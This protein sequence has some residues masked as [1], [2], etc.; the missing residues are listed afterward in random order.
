MTKMQIPRLKIALQFFESILAFMG[1]WNCVVYSKL[2]M[3]ILAIF[4]IIIS[5]VSLWISYSTSKKT[6]NLDLIGKRPYLV[7]A[8]AKFQDQKYISFARKNDKE[9]VALISL[10]ITNRGDT[11]AT[12]IVLPE[13]GKVSQPSKGVQNDFSFQFP[14]GSI[15]VGP[16]ES[17]FLE[18]AAG[19]TAASKEKADRDL[20]K[21]NEVALSFATPIHY[22]SLVEPDT[23]YKSVFSFEISQ[24]KVVVLEKGIE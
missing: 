5:L 20:E 16:G 9:F 13:G 11:P 3:K 6:H 10:E 15:S 8:P 24:D 17:I 1:K 18:M 14:K 7:V 2:N 4:A 21:T 19:F 23:V 12:N 22:S